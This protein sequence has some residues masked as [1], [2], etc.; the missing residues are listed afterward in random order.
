MYNNYRINNDIYCI[1]CGE[2]YPITKIKSHLNLCKSLFESKTHTNV[3]LPPEYDIFLSPYPP[4]TN[5]GEI[6]DLNFQLKGKNI[7]QSVDYQIQKEKYSE[8]LNIIKESKIP[9]KEKRL[10]GQR[11]R[12]CRCPLCG[13]EFAISA[14]KIHI[15]TC[16]NKEIKNQQF[17]PKKYWKDVDKIIENFRKGLEGGNTNIKIKTKGKYDIDN[18][19]E[20]AFVKNDN[21]IECNFCGRKFLEDRINV[22]QKI[23]SKHPEMF[24]KNKK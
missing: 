13:T 20:N 3:T 17:L 24:I 7:S 15:K 19:D 6:S 1:I 10:K 5:S 4:Y 2:T 16:R 12:T 21:L 11:P 8:Y 18:L 9:N 14:W 23:C 22:H